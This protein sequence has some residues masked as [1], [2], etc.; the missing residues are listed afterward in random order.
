MT[1]WNLQTWEKRGN[2]N[3]LSF[4]LSRHPL[5][6]CEKTRGQ[7]R[8][9]AFPHQYGHASCNWLTTAETEARYVRIVA[10][11]LVWGK[12]HLC[13]GERQESLPENN[14]TARRDRANTICCWG[15]DRKPMGLGA[16]ALIKGK[17]QLPLE[18]G[19]EHWDQVFSSEA[20]VHTP[21][22]ILPLE[23]ENQ[24]TLCSSQ[25]PCNTNNNKK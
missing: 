8:T 15:W 18:V 13:V 1:L 9:G 3:H 21:C 23:Q 6:A 22:L 7:E 14:T 10:P 12:S 17:I 5:G 11:S 25:E 4:L 16:L 2:Y 20:K 24:E 19:W